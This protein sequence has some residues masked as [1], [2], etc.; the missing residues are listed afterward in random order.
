MTATALFSPITVY[1]GDSM[2]KFRVYFLSFVIAFTSIVT[3]GRAFALGFGNVQSLGVVAGLSGS[4]IITRGA[5]LLLGPWGTLAGLAVG[6]YISGLYLTGSNGD[7][8]NVLP[9]SVSDTVTLGVAS[10]TSTVGL[11]YVVDGTTGS[12]PEA[13]CSASVGHWA[14]GSIVLCPGASSYVTGSGSA[15]NQQMANAGSSTCGGVWTVAIT[16]TCPQNYSLIN[17]VCSWVSSASQ[18]GQLPQTEGYK[19]PVLIGGEPLL[20]DLPTAAAKPLVSGAPIRV[21]TNPQQTVEIRPLA[22]GGIQTTRRTFDPATQTTTVETVR[23]DSTGKVVSNATSEAG[24]DVTGSSSSSFS[25]DLPTD[26]NR[27]PTQQQAV[28]KLDDIKT[29]TGAMD[30][31]DYDVAGKTT[32]KT[33]DITDKL[34]A[35][36]NQYAGDK[37]NWFSWVWTPPVGQCQPWT[38]VVHGRTVSWNVCP[39]VDKIR[40]VIGYLLAVSTAVVVYGQLFRRED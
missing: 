19:S 17:G 33:K 5:S 1:I 2:K 15:C 22:D 36:P 7:T 8:V 18:P 30:E 3:P 20:Q 37:G 9:K 13:A 26:Y 27:E 4:G 16:Q 14:S 31:P 35:L 38:S 6:T 34:D 40:D 21:S 10:T 39:Y 11:V 23:T 25:I 29:G 28:Q 24:G 32:S 12:T